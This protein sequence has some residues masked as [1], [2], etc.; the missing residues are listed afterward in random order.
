MYPANIIAK[1]PGSYS[2][3]LRIVNDDDNIC[4]FISMTF[5][6]KTYEK[7]EDFVQYCLNIFGTEYIERKEN[8]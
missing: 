6:A 4:I 2:S 3:H 5:I 7:R 1:H 8:E